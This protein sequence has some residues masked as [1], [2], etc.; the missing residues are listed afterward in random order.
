MHISL[1][2]AALLFYCFCMNFSISNTE[3]LLPHLAHTTVI[4]F[5][6]KL[7]KII[8]DITESDKMGSVID[9]QAS[10]IEIDESAF[11]KKQ[12]YNRGKHTKKQWVFGLVERNTR[13]TYFTP[14]ANRTKDTLLS[15]IKRKVIPGSMIYHDDWSAYR[16]LNMHGYQH[17][18]VVHTKEFV[19]AT[20]A[21]T[22][23]IEGLYIEL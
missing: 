17:D 12:K 1:N 18:V 7:R 13:K 5:Y 22:N 6:K 4:N 11:G 19:S 3:K 2:E 21:C 23:T 16:D 14:V 15:I 9:G 20:G 10:I 8:Y